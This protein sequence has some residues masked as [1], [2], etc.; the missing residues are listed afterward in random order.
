MYSLSLILFPLNTMFLI[1]DNIILLKKDPSVNVINHLFNLINLRGCMLIYQ[2]YIYCRPLK[3]DLMLKICRKICLP[4]VL[5]SGPPAS[6]APAVAPR[7]AGGGRRAS[8]IDSLGP[9]FP[10]PAI[11]FAAPANGP[12]LRQ[13][14]MMTTQYACY[15]LCLCLCAHR[16]AN[17]ALYL[18]SHS[19][20]S[21]LPVPEKQPSVAKSDK[22]CQRWL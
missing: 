11:C 5:S 10:S 2:V 22:S 14:S 9:R 16:S 20:V 4:S 17:N 7:T 18:A 1:Q 12:L 6:S 15:V 8:S 19:G 3:Y 21:T 13:E